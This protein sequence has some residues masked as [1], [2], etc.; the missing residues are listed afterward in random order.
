SAL[1]YVE[2]RLDPAE[3]RSRAGGAGRRDLFADACRRPFV[4]ADGLQF[5]CWRVRAVGT[6]ADRRSGAG[7]H[8]RRMPDDGI[9]EPLYDAAERRQYR[10]PVGQ[11]TQS[12]IVAWSAALHPL[13]NPELPQDP[14]EA[15]IVSQQIEPRID[16]HR[17]QIE[18]AVGAGL[19]EPG[20]AEVDV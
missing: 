20:E 17:D 5:V 8:A 9:R 11:H 1:G 3:R 10:H 15:A 12:V 16:A 13:L 2:R 19:A 14:C 7:V 4:N 6:D 18:G